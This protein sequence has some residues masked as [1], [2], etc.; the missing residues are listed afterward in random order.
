MIPGE[1]FLLK[2]FRSSFSFRK[3]EGRLSLLLLPGNSS[4]P[5][6][7]RHSLLLS[8]ARALKIPAYI[9]KLHVS[10]SESGGNNKIT[11]FVC[12]YSLNPIVLE[13]HGVWCPPM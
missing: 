13:N 4:R 2:H 5:Y 3:S 1:E 6:K 8:M 11:V 10:M 9:L 7:K 12:F